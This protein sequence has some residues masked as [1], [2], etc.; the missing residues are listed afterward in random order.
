M[1][2]NWNKH[3]DGDLPAIEY[4][5]GTKIWYKNGVKHRDGDLPAVIFPDGHQEWW[6]NGK[7]HRDNGPA[8]IRT[9]GRIFYFK[10]GEE[11]I[12]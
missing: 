3:R 7:L 1:N 5:D 12:S 4:K 8:I 2:W 6:V 11:H 10:N 9:E